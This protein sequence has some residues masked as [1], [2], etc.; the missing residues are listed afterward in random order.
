MG[1]PMGVI[2][3]VMGADL[4]DYQ[5]LCFGWRTGVRGSAGGGGERVFG[6]RVFGWGYGE[7]YG[8]RYDYCS[9]YFSRHFLRGVSSFRHC[10]ALS[11]G[12]ESVL[13]VA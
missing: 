8:S 11:E 10:Q 9:A 5:H 2:G 4:R 7:G 13:S 12:C 1:N 3:L 6:E